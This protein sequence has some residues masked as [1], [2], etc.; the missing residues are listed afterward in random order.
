[1]FFVVFK[2][3]ASAGVIAFASWLSG[4][5]PELAGFI[6]AM[7]ILTL[8]VLPFSYVEYADPEASAQ[9]ARSILFGVPISL[10]FFIPFL[11]AGPL[12]AAGVGFYGLYA[13]GVAMLVAGY[14]LH[15]F[16]M[17]LF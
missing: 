3:L 1:M 11:F 6:V 17:K 15:Q 9:F 16:I 10:L 7:P 2:V 5:K 14:F 8:I 4:K 12:K 13:G